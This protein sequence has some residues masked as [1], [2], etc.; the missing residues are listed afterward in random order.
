[1]TGISFDVF[2]I[3]CCMLFFNVQISLCVR[4]TLRTRIQFHNL[5]IVNLG[6]FQIII[7][8]VCL[9]EIIERVSVLV[10]LV[11]LDDLLII[12]N[13]LS[14]LLRIVCLGRLL[15]H[16]TDIIRVDLRI[17]RIVN[18]CSRIA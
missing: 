9:C 8:A 10:C 6:I 3:L 5:L 16:R 12:L 18:A 17:D 11:K 13:R 14:E 4:R 1:M 7:P 15:V 2:R